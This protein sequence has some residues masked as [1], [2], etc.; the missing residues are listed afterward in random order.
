MMHWLS[1]LVTA[2]QRFWFTPEAPHTLALLRILNGCMLLYTHL[3]WGQQLT[4][5]LGPHAWINRNVAYELNTLADGTNYTWSYWYFVDSPGMVWMLHML[6]LLIFFLYTIGCYTRITAVLAWLV[7]VS[8]S[9][10]LVGMQFGLD[11][12]NAFM[13][14]Y[15]MLGE[16]GQ[17]YSFDAWRQHKNLIPTATAQVS[18]NIAVRLLQLHLCVIYL[19]GGISKMRGELWWDGSASW[20]A[21][22]NYE[23]QSL[24]MTWLIQFPFILACITHLTV[25]W[26]T[27]YCFLVWPK[28]TR[29]LALGLAVLVH[30]GIAFCL[31]MITFGAAMLCANM[32]FLSPEYVEAI[33]RSWLEKS[34]KHAT[35]EF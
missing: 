33:R 8:Y 16:S 24:N 13:V 27:F 3:I 25:F 29:P 23:Y 28:L 22:A 31:G 20:F 14:M 21:F 18:T 1:Q 34:T 10:R 15:I 7:T 6:G 17:V 5:M 35:S 30:G 4:H 32:V 19:F 12:I 2:W 26:E 11:Q 9:H